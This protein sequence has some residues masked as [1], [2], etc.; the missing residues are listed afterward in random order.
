[1]SSNIEVYTDGGFAEVETLSPMKKLGPGES[2][3]HTERWELSKT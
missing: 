3:L 1:M 2:V